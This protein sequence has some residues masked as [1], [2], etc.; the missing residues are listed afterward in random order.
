[1]KKRALCVIGLAILLL[2]GA[3]GWTM[4]AVS[5][6]ALGRWTVDGGG[7]VSST[8]GSHT[9]S[10]TIGQ[11]DAHTWSG[12]SYTLNGGFWNGNAGEQHVYLPL[13]IRE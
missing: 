3:M 5:D 7:N 11:P 6:L 9:L 8:S 12:G 2:L 4:A 1:M 10:S 13:V